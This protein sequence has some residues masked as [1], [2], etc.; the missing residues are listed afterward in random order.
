MT[1]PRCLRYGKNHSGP[2]LKN[3][4]ACFGCGEMGPLD[5]GISIISEKLPIFKFND[6]ISLSV[7]E[8]LKKLVTKIRQ[9]RQ[10]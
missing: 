10:I 2:Y 8:S 5:L 4:N 1:N 3:Y 7:F 6:S 9:F